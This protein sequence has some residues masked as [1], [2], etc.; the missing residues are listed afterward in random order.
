MGLFNTKVI[1]NTQN[2][3]NS[4]N[5]GFFQNVQVFNND[6][7][8]ITDDC[9]IFNSCIKLV[10]NSI[11]KLDLNLVWRDENKVLRKDIT[12]NKY[13]LLKY[14]PNPFQNAFQFWSSLI[15]N[16]LING[17]S[18]AIINKNSNGSILSINPIPNKNITNI[19]LLNSGELKY[20]IVFERNNERYEEIFAQRDILHFRINSQNGINGRGFYEFVKDNLDAIQTVQNAYSNYYKNNIFNTKTI[21]SSVS[22]DD[23]DNY[24]INKGIFEELYTGAENAGKPL[25]LPANYKISDNSIDFKDE[26]FIKTIDY[27]S[28]IVCSLFGISPQLLN[29]GDQKSSINYENDILNFYN[30]GLQPIITSIEAELNQKLLSKK[31]ILEDKRFSFDLNKLFKLDINKTLDYHNKLYYDGIESARDIINSMDILDSQRFDGDD[32][33]IKQNNLSL[34]STIDNEALKQQAEKNNNNLNE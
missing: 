26:I 34:L 23:F 24:I 19:V 32:V 10:S 21:E 17:N 8:Y 33:H 14:K 18:Y 2:F 9:G 4:L 29:I 27:N 13:Y 6:K 25:I 11:S 1:D 5:F 15:D 3:S 30:I 28:K 12:N 16:L 31:Q 7:Q 20:S 22:V